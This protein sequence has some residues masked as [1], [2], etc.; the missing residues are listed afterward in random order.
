MTTRKP[1]SLNNPSVST[2]S[3]PNW[4]YE[5][6]ISYVI[7]DQLGTPLPSDIDWNEQWTTGV[8][9]V[10]PGTNWPQNPV[11]PGTALYSGFAGGPLL[12]DIISG[13]GVNNQPPNIPQ[14]TYNANPSV[15]VVKWGQAFSVGSL[16]TGAGA[17]VQ[18]DTLHKWIDHGAHTIP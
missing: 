8:T 11:S 17:R 16:Q 4:G 9:A 5:T 14:P 15:E 2:R 6:D 7:F 1:A 18:Q 10:Y 12:L 3:D 13:P